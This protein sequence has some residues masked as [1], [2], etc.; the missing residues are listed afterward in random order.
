MLTSRWITG[1]T[2]AA[3]ADAVRALVGA[4]ATADGVDA[5]AEPARRDIAALGSGGGRPGT[6]HLLVH[7]EDSLVGHAL[8]D[9]EHPDDPVAELAVVPARRREGVGA[10]LVDAVVEA[11]P[12]ARFWAH[13]DHPGAAHLAERV[14]RRRVRELWR[15]R[16][17]APG[18]EAPPLPELVAPDGTVIRPLRVGR[19]EDAVVAVNN[20]AFSWHPEQGG[21]TTADVAEIEAESW[22]DAAGVLLAWDTATEEL[23]GFHFTKVHAVSATVAEPLGEVYVVGVDPSA[24]GRGLG[25]ALTLAGLHHLTDRGLRTTILYVEGDNAAAIATYRALGFE[26]DAV[27]VSYQR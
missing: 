3:D 17:P 20:R 2:S 23:L 11:A 6:R 1:A 4:V 24:Q 26:R 10:V 12:Q 14:G 8:L 15:M 7:D 25:K 5:Y 19:D 18:H 27:D 22:F 21:W 9:T 13:G 16:R